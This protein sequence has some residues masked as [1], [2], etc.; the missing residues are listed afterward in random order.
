MR[1]IATMG[2]GMVMV[3][4][5]GKGGTGA[6]G[7]GT[8]LGEATGEPPR[9]AIDAP[10]MIDASTAPVVTTGPAP[11]WWK[12]ATPCPAGDHLDGAAPPNGTHVLCKRAD[13]V[14]DGPEAWF[15]DKGR[16]VS[17]GARK[18]GRQHG[19]AIAFY[20][21]GKKHR[22]GSYHAGN[23][24]GAWTT[25]WPNG[26]VFLEE[27]YVDGRAD[28]EQRAFGQDGALRERWSLA[29]GTGTMRY[30]NDD[31]SKNSETEY[32]DGRA[33]GAST[34]FW[35]NGKVQSKGHY[36]EGE[37]DG[38][39]ESWDDQGRLTERGTYARGTQVGDWS[40]FE[41]GAQTELVRRDRDGD[42]LFE[43]LYQDGQPLVPVPGKSACADKK[44]LAAAAG[45]P[46]SSRGDVP[47]CVQ[48]IRHFPGLAVVGSFAYD[49]G[50]MGGQWLADCKTIAPPAAP[51]VLARGGWAKAKGQRRE[52]LALAYL[53]EVV[54]LWG[55]PSTL[56]KPDPRA[57][58]AAADG[59]VVVTA[60][61]ASG[62][63]GM[64]RQT[65]RTL[66]QVQWRFAPDGAMTEKTLQTRTEKLGTD[67][68]Y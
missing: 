7:T 19:L 57:A 59:S 1:V 38:L 54:G 27:H 15:D 39:D 10:P 9:P 46:V 22:E 44:A 29:M 40:R 26:K 61:T 21:D 52:A 33:H 8:G 25:W 55:G 34:S 14:E 35:P 23:Q 3:V 63:S 47:D 12:Q 24:H 37:P 41:G 31:G 48:R 49:A 51:A 68:S 53:D 50:C 62:R 20:P 43:L 5:C 45:R 60:W 36:V 65:E 18:D 32:V 64:V 28:G 13:N 58:V 67:P 11:D 2:A 16:L 56:D 42:E 17:I 30:W 4:A 6:G 66:T